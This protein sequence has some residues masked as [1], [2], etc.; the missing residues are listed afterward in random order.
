MPSG[1]EEAYIESINVVRERSV[2]SI[3][4]LLSFFFFVRYALIE[5]EFSISPYIPA[6]RKRSLSII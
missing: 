4:S 6:L 3:V 2:A 1:V 5:E